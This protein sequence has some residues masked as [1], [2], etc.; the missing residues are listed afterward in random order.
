MYCC[1]TERDK[2]ERSKWEADKKSVG[3]KRNSALYNSRFISGKCFVF[4]NGICN[5]VTNTERFLP[6]LS[7]QEKRQKFACVYRY[8]HTSLSCLS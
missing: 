4:R 6:V 3:I 7:N 5:V 1:K 2:T 8:F